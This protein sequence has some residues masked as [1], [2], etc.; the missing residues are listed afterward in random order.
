MLALTLA[1]LVTSLIDRVRASKS[2]T[3][4]LA[5]WR[6][7][8]EV[9]SRAGV[10]RYRT[11]A[12]LGLVVDEDGST[13]RHAPDL[14]LQGDEV[15]LQAVFAGRLSPLAAWREGQLELEG[16]PEDCELLDRLLMARVA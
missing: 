12:A 2:L 15:A 1:S 3:A 9:R 10:V 14:V 16:A 13:W 4:D 5:G 7:I 8:I 11:D 6:R